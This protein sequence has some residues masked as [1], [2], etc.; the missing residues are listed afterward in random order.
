[1]PGKIEVLQVTAPGAA[2]GLLYGAIDKPRPGSEGDG[3][4]LDIRGAAVGD[5][6]PVTHV[7]VVGP[8]GVIHTA[9]CDAA[10]PALAAEHPDLPGAE[11]PS[12]FYGNPRWP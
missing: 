6:P 2:P 7:E 8:G 12:G 11:D 5:G 1:M 3:W 4:T 10:R 9:P